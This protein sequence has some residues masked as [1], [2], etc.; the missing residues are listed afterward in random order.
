MGAFAVFRLIQAHGHI[1]PG[2]D[3]LGD[4]G[5]L[6]A[7]ADGDE[8]VLGVPQLIHHGSFWAAGPGH[9]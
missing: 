3:G 1:V 8:H 6:G 5:G 9:R 4:L 2:P 7:V